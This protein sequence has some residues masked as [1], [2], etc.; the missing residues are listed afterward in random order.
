MDSWVRPLKSMLGAIF[1][2]LYIVVFVAAYVDYRIHVDEWFADLGLILIV[3]PFLLTMRFLSGG[4]FNLTGEDS[5][6]LLAGAL[7][8]G[9]LAWLVGAALEWILRAIFRIARTRRST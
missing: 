4:S 7:F 5:A 1:A 6:K 3:M 9:A 8:C 2:S